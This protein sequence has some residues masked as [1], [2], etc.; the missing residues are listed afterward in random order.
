MAPKNPM[1]HM[2]LWP[3]YRKGLTN[4]ASPCANAFMSLRVFAALPIPD[5]IADPVLSLM[6]HVP[7]ARWRPREN[8]HI[9]LAFYGE[10]DGLV[11]EGLDAELACVS[12]AGFELKLSGVSRFGRKEPSALWL[13]VEE[14]STLKAL[15]K[16]CRR[17]GERAGVQLERR[18]YLPHLTIAYLKPL[19]DLAPLQRFEQR[20]SLWRSET[21][22][23]DRFHLY[24]S[25]A[26]KP[27]RP[28]VYE[29]QAVYPL[30]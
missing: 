28:N 6:D 4:T 12:R 3:F 21:F 18:S 25:H 1:N 27:G 26:R 15:A 8:L 11:I 7:G 20:H 29:I 23:A 22:R 13:G 24:S 19:L 30:G 9:T 10:L 14:N 16:A 5:E 2:G 17:A